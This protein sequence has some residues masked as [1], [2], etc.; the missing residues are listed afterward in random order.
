MESD[1]ETICS[2]LST[3]SVKMDKGK[4]IVE[5][6]FLIAN[7]VF[8]TLNAIAFCLSPAYPSILVTAF[9]FVFDALRFIL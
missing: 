2:Q 5:K 1:Y 4:T 3:T 8:G 9:F 6:T 7:C